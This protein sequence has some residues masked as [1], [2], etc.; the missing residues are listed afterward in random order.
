MPRLWNKSDP[1][2]ADQKSLI[3]K[4]KSFIGQRNIFI[5][6]TDLKCW[7]NNFY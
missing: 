3:R 7:S 2:P 5:A 4:Q 6:P 1:V